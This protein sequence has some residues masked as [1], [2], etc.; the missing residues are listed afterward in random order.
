MGFIKEEG[1]QP[2]LKK[3]RGCL[4][5]VEHL[6]KIFNAELPSLN[7]ITNLSLTSINLNQHLIE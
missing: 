1:F 6:P 7:Q 4:P 5:Q 2:S 3:Q